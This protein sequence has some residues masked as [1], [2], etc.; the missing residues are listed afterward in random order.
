MNIGP[1]TKSVWFPPEEDVS[2][3]SHVYTTPDA[4]N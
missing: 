2:T 4:D 3:I 1:K